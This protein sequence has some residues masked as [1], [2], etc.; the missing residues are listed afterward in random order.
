MK[1]ELITPE[2][3]EYILNS[4]KQYPEL[5]LQNKGY[6][7]INKSALS[8]EAKEVLKSIETILNNSIVGFRSFSNFKINKAGELQLRVQYNY[9]YDN[10]LAPFTGVG[11]IL[12]DELL[13][14]FTVE[15]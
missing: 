10:N 4:Y 12:L 1:I 2:Q 15:S 3:H 7:Y 9:S 6:E 8:D 11:Y 13:N 14:G 5:T